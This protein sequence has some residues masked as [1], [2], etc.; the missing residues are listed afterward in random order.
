M[1]NLL[2]L[3]VSVGPPFSDWARDKLA[4][5]KLQSMDGLYNPSHVFTDLLGLSSRIYQRWEAR[6]GFPVVKPIRLTSAKTASRIYTVVQVHLI[7]LWYWNGSVR[8]MVDRATNRT[9]L[10]IAEHLCVSY[11]VAK[12]LVRAGQ[13]PA[14]FEQAC[15]REHY[16]AWL[17]SRLF[18]EEG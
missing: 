13:L 8:T 14:T 16:T 1:S 12:R 10:D 2:E 7:M 9:W 6:R 17:L 15:T 4:K 11:D 3:A 5:S 18:R